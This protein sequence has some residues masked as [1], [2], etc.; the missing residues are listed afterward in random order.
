MKNHVE[1]LVV[2]AL[3][4]N[5]YLYP[6]VVQQAPLDLQEGAPR[7]PCV[8]IDPGDEA[9]LILARLDALQWQPRVILLTH[10]HFDHLAA[11]PALLSNY[12]SNI[13]GIEVAIHAADAAYLG[14]GAYQTHVASFMAVAGDSSYVDAF[15]RDLPEPTRLLADGDRIGALEVL[16]LPGHSQGSVAFYD[17]AAGLIFS[18]DT[19]FKDGFGR[20]DL[21]GG[22]E[23]ALIT[24]I[25]RL[26]ALDG[27]IVMYSGHGAASTLGAEKM[28]YRWA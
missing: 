17:R 23:R 8:V 9:D 4:T 28:G 26:F 14:A 27:N 13:E 19:L 6:L 24:S 21:P 25:K 5:C 15:W 12:A 2:G 7:Q 22:N 10:G 18:G 11:L 3:S 16:H 1:T 20:T